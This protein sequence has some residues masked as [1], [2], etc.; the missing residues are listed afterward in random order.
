MKQLSIKEIKDGYEDE[1]YSGLSFKETLDREIHPYRIYVI[2]G[3]GCILY[4]GKSQDAIAR[5]ESHVRKGQWST[6]FGSTVDWVLIKKEADDYIV[7][8]YDEEEIRA[9]YGHSH[10]YTS[11]DKV[12]SDV[13]KKMIFDLAPVFNT[14]YNRSEN[15]ENEDRWYSLHPDPTVDIGVSFTDAFFS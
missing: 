13:E 8:L 10:F 2:K 9:L 6:F 1:R 5:M 4:V 3:D 15:R 11:I 7:E 12:V 14:I